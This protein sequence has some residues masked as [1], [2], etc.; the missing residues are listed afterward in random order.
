MKNLEIVV[1]DDK[2]EI[3]ELIKTFILCL[4]QNINIHTFTNSV[5]AKNFIEKNKFDILITDYKMPF[6]NGLQLIEMCPPNVKKILISGYI[7]EIA[8]EKLQKLNAFF[9]VKPVPLRALSKII[10][11]QEEKITK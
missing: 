8:E 1:V 11:E 9:F 4:N 5:E 2:E 3:T 6:Y 7:S 10:F